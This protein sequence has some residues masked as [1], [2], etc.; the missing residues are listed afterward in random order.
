MTALTSAREPHQ[1]YICFSLVR[2]QQIQKASEL[3]LIFFALSIMTLPIIPNCGLLG[4][5]QSANSEQEE[6]YQTPSLQ[7]LLCLS[8]CS[9]S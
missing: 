6:A 1:F 4:V 5:M 9:N 3:Y 2:L 8:A 7:T